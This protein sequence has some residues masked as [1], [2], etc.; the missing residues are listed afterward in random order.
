[1][2][3]TLFSPLQLRNLTLRNRIVMSP[4]CIY[5]AGNDGLA[6]DWHFVHYGTRATGGVG[7]IIQEATAVESRGRIGEQ[8]LGLWDD[9]QIAPL[10]R[11]VDFVHAQGAA[12]GVQLAHAGRKA[13]TRHKGRGPEPAVG[14]GSHPFDADFLPPRPLSP[15]DIDVIVAAFAAAT[16]RALAAGYDVIEIHGAHGY[17]LHS[18]VSPLSNQR[19]DDYGGSIEHRARFLWRVAEAVR[20]EW[21][22]DRPLFTRISASD[23]HP[24][25]LTVTD[26]EP[27]VAGLKARGVDVIDCS[28][29]GGVPDAVIPLGPGYQIPFAAH[30]RQTCDV[31]TMTVGLITQPET[32]DALIRNGQADLVALGRELLRHPYWPLDAARWLGAEHAWPR[33]YI[34]AK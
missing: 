31:Q 4:M 13:W 27:V 24:G 28:A 30:L 1:M 26:W 8:D 22:V 16:Q 29:G 12:M 17:L 5:S 6:T 25:G 33:Q 14:P 15:A 3:P 20:A 19:T 9:A 21:P 11:I 18:F 2:I 7:L 32:A 10:A 23:W 34:R